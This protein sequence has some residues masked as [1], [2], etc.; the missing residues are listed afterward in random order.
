MMVEPTEQPEGCRACGTRL[1]WA[2]SS[3]T[4]NWLPL[5]RT[6]HAYRVKDGIAEPADRAVPIFISH[7]LTCRDPERFRRG[8]R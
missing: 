2:R 3:V 6:R 7:F 4:G 8:R 5:E 1:T